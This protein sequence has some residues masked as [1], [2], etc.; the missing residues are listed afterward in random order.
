MSKKNT[1]LARLRCTNCGEVLGPGNTWE[2]IGIIVGGCAGGI[3]G[4]IGA[5]DTPQEIGSATITTGV[6]GG[7]TVGGL[8]GKTIDGSLPPTCQNCDATQNY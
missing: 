7:I 1:A 2:N 8:I 3:L 4:V 6:I 5:D